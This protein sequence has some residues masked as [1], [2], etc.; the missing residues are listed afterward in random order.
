[1]ATFG[2]CVAPEDAAPVR[3]AGWDFI[4][5]N[6]QSVFQGRITDD[7]AWTG[8]NR[9]AAA[10]LPAPVAN[11]LVPG[12][13]KI[14]GPTANLDA[15]RAYLQVV[16]RRATACGTHTLVFGSGVARNIPEGFDH[17]RARTQ[18]LEFARMSAE[19]AQ[20]HG[21]TLVCEPLNR[22]ECNVINSVAEA[23]EYVRAVDHPNFQCLVDSYH[24]WLEAEPLSNL[25]KAMPWIRHVHVADRDGRVAPGQSGRPE[26]DYRAFFATLKS[27][28]YDG[29]ISV[30]AGKF[31]DTPGSYTTVLSYLRSA[32]ASV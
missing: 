32:W 17:D 15:L 9:L 5:V 4:E 31:L 2:I 3:A 25:S 14:V 20:P 29:R 23:M 24:F 1:M 30:E 11:V 7:N 21:V 13:L 10:G 18:I 8:R 22:G 19:I 12:D 16:L 26:S 28:G 27:G 6:V